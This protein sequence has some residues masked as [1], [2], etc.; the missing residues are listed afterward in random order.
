MNTLENLNKGLERNLKENYI[1]YKEDSNLSDE[2]YL[3]E[4]LLWEMANVVGKYVKSEMEPLNFS[5]HY[6]IL[7]IYK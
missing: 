6:C 2:E 4:V 3:H 7:Y 5:F 1:I